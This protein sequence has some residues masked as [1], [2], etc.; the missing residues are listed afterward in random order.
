MRNT[1]DIALLGLALL[2]LPVATPPA[3]GVEYEEMSAEAGA[4]SIMGKKR[5]VFRVFAIRENGIVSGTG[6]LL[7]EDGVLAT[8]RHVE[9]GAKSLFVFILSP[10]SKRAQAYSATMVIEDIDNDL[11]LL[12]LDN[13][14]ADLPAP[15]ALSEL[16]AK[17]FDEVVAVGFPAALDRPISEAADLSKVE[18]TDP[19]VLENLDPNLTKGAVSKVGT[20]VVHD[21]KIS[22]GNSGGPLINIKT[23]MVVGVN[24]AKTMGNTSFFEAVPVEKVSALL[25]LAQG[26]SKDLEKLEK[27]VAENDADAMGLLGQLLYDGTNGFPFEPERGIK[28]LERAAELGNREA[29]ACLGN[30][31]HE[32][33]HVKQDTEKAVEYLKRSG[34]KAAKIFLFAIYAFGEDPSY[35]LQPEKAFQVAKELLEE[36][37]IE[38]KVDMALCY[39]KGFGTKK[40]LEQAIKLLEEVE[41]ETA[42]DESKIIAHYSAKLSLAHALMESTDQAHLEAGLQK[43]EE[44]IQGEDEEMA[45][46]ACNTLAIYYLGDKKRKGDQKKHIH[47]L[48]LG[49]ER[50]D[51]YCMENLAIAY[52]TGDRGVP[53]N[54]TAGESLANEAVERGGDM[55]IFFFVGSALVKIKEYQ[56]G[57]AYM[58]KAAENGSDK[59][60]AYLGLG[61]VAGE[62]G[63]KKNIPAGLELLRQ[64]AKSRKDPDAAE[65][66]R[67]ILQQYNRVSARP[68]TSSRRTRRTGGGRSAPAAPKPSSKPW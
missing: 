4:A 57:L 9:A 20:W 31:Y 16:P 53:K 56:K 13:P 32:G 67:K 54:L 29:L 12:R 59:A 7:T 48:R 6:F 66:A 23:G 10:D 63:L 5:A 1:T 58:R 62:Y 43:L 11:A 27:K 50:K 40:D 47:Y 33:V 18:L 19:T 52:L 68:S 42:N 8:N 25:D 3:H 36:D 38:G 26:V 21:A 51:T 2:F 41:Q 22:S 65:L 49:A 37:P 28:L 24:T 14:P 60:K 64:A 30:I 61:M 35:P 15:F 44:I 46:Q 17:V 45:G 34:T 55:D 39:R